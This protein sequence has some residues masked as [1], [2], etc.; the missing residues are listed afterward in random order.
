VTITVTLV[1]V[2]GSTGEGGVIVHC[3][4]EAGSVQEKVSGVAKPAAALIVTVAELD[5]PCVTLKVVTLA[6]SVN[7]CVTVTV[8][9]AEVEFAEAQLPSNVAVML[10]LAIGKEVVEKVATPLLVR[11]AVPSKVVPL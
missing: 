9:G 6:E 10:L 11:A 7:G 8:N 4:S 5:A 3:D 1:V 2:E